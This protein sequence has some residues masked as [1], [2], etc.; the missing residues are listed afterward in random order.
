V[1]DG[2]TMVGREVLVASDGMTLPADGS[3]R[4]AVD[5][6]SGT[7]ALQVNVRD[8]SGTLVR[9]MT[10]PTDA[11]LSDFSWDGLADN[12]ARAP[13]GEYSFEAIANVGGKSTS[14]EMLLA[15]RVSSVTIDAATGLTLNTNGLGARSLSDVR[16]VM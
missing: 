8:A 2:A 12:G 7:N 4:G 10:L 11:G 16:R 13:A 1:L 6:P 9:R 5:V 15:S 3:V 14:L